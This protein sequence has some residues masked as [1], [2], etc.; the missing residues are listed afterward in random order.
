MPGIRKR[1]GGYALLLLRATRLRRTSSELAGSIANENELVYVGGLRR[2]G[3]A[4]AGPLS[5]PAAACQPHARH[6]LR[7]SQAA[8]QCVLIIVTRDLDLTGFSYHG[9]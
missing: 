8:S 9:E 1:R 6:P 7:R 4:Q 5:G 3:P 2:R